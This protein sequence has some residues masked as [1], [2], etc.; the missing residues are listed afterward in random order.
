[1]IEITKKIICVYINPIK[2]NNN[3]FGRYK[4]LCVFQNILILLLHLPYF[5]RKYCNFDHVNL[6]IRNFSK[7]CYQ[8][9]EFIK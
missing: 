8:I 7:R 9:Y 2:S 4:I 6:S 1:M 5:F 3:E